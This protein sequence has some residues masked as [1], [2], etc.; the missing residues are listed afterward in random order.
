MARYDDDEREAMGRGAS[1]PDARAMAEVLVSFVN[2]RDMERGIDNLDT[3]SA[4]Q[5]WLVRHALAN[6][7]VTLSLR[8]LDLARHLREGLRAIFRCH[9]DVDTVHVAVDVRDR[10]NRAFQTLPLT[11]DVDEQGELGWRAATDAPLTG[12]AAIVADLCRRPEW[13]RLKACRNPACQWAFYDASKNQSHQW[14]S[15]AVCG[16]RMKA[17][18][19]RRRRRDLQVTGVNGAKAR[20]NDA[21]EAGRSR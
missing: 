16:S 13:R 8:D 2:T 5:A 1:M 10:V 14:C 18:R 4:L 9:S 19:Y 3:V 6:A 17:R 11:L 21:G 20:A 7:N 12:I 15:M